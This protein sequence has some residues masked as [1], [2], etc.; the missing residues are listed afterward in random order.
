MKQTSPLVLALCLVCPWLLPAA[1][2]SVE[3]EKDGIVIKI[4]NKLFTKYVTDGEANKPYFWPL[5]GPTGKSMTRAFPME[6]VPGEKQDHPHHRSMW[7]GFQGINGVDTWHEPATYH[8][9]FRTKPD[10]LAKRL[11]GLGS[12]VHTTTLKAEALEDRAILETEST[13]LDNGGA[14]MLQDRRWFVFQ[15]DESSNARVIDVDIVLTGTEDTVTLGDAKDA[16]FSLRVAHSMS[17]DAKQGGRII[18]SEGQEDKEAWSKPAKWVNFNGM[19]EGEKLGI[20]MLNHPTSFRY[21]NRWHVRTYGLFTANPFGSKSMDK[22][23]ED[24]TVTLKK[25]E[26]LTLRYRVILHEGDEKSA[27]IAQ[28]FEAYAAQ[29]F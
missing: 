14:P 21:P 25:G 4:D 20:A 9:R 6:D 18:N 3:T 10:E 23:A 29:T 5:I 17:V 16:G 26:T 1:E 27:N 2:F 13:Y 22:S 7:F 15:V 19:V 12:I 11:G 24:G 28:A 8:E